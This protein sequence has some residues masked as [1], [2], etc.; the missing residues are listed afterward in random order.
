LLPYVAVDPSSGDPRVL[1]TFN[2]FS[3]SG[4]ATGEVVYVNYGRI[5]DFQA[6]QAAGVPLKGKVALA[7]YAHERARAHESTSRASADGVDLVDDDDADTA[8]SSVAPR[9]CWRS[10]SA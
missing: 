3:P 10:S 6:L 8:P 5:E 2:G 7:R 1:P 4:I 9:P